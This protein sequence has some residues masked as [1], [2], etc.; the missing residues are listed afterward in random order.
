MRLLLKGVVLSSELPV[1]HGGFAN[2]FH[3]TYKDSHGNQVDIAL[4]VLKIFQDQTDEQRRVLNK[5]FV[6]E[7]SVWHSLTHKNIVPLLGIDLTT[8]PS[9]SRA[10]VSPWM[11]FGSVLRYMGEHS[12]SSSYAI[13]MLHDVTQGLAYLHSVKVVH[14]DLCG[15]NIL[16]DRDGRA[17]LTD[18]GLATFIDLETA[19]KS[20]TR[21]G[22]I[23]WMAPELLLPPLGLAFKRTLASDIWALGCVCCEI[24]SE[25]NM[26]FSQFTTDAGI[27]LAVSERKESP[28]PSR[29]HDKAGNIMV[30]R[31]WERSQ[32]C[33]QYEPSERPTVQIMAAMF[34]C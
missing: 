13:N 3:G 21:S 4:K 32:W 12:P 17:R 6:K 16:I 7:A 28:Y 9:P 15:R 2:V 30:D 5:K 24:W 31:L 1:K 26:P 22:T 27:I 8:F 18:F 29:P 33:F 14:G 19:N 20:S 34:S 11:P 23:R 10:M 25:G